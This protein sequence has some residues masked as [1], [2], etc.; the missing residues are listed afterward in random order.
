MT[1]PKRLA[2]GNPQVSKGYGDAVVKRY[3][4]ALPDWKK[5]VGERIDRLVDQSVPDVVKA[6]KWN[7]VLY[8]L[9]R[10]LWF[11]SFR[12]HKHYAKVGFFQG[13]RLDPTPP[14]TSERDAIRYLH[15]REGEAF[16]PQ[17][18]DWITQARALPGLKL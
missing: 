3:I 6:V 10:D 1:E 9:E 2:G 18:A 12:V 7:T 8:G 17:L 16:E 15:I 5:P 11:M 14:E 13:A 4:S